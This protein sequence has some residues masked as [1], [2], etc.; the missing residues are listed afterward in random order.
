VPSL[1]LLSCSKLFITHTATKIPFMLF[2]SGNCAAS[3]SPNFHNHVSVSDLY[4]P[5][6]GPH[7]FLQQNRQIH[8]VGI[9]KSQTL[10]L[11]LWPRN[12]FTGNICFNFLVLFLCSAKAP[13][14]RL[15]PFSKTFLHSSNCRSKGLLNP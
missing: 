12:S 8:R 2:F 9:Y 1:L 14:T 7:I 15:Q 5:K 3:V 13:E 11:G 6:I 10:K 4:L